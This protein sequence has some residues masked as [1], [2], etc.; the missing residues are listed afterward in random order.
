MFGYKEKI[1]NRVCESEDMN[2]WVVLFQYI[3]YGVVGNHTFILF[4]GTVLL[5]YV[6]TFICCEISIRI[7]FVCFLKGT[8]H[9]LNK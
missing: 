9:S 8:K 4:I 7:P 2:L 1:V 3:L 6:T 5:A